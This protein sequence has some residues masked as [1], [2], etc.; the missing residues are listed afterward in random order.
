MESLKEQVTRLLDELEF[1]YEIDEERSVFEFAVNAGNADVDVILHYDEEGMRLY[2]LANLEFSLPKDGITAV[3]Y[4][5]N[6]IHN[7]SFSQAHLYIDD[8]D[9]R[10]NAGAVIDVPENGLDKDVFGYFLYS[11]ISMLNKYFN[12]IMSAAYGQTN[13]DNKEE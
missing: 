1:H 4:K 12:D 13:H 8:E 7:K 10:L 5:I 9:N 3:L 2:N 11:T 6:E